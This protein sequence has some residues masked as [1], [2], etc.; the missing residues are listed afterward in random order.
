M[1]KGE[2]MDYKELN[3][4]IRKIANEHTKMVTGLKLPN[5]VLLQFRKDDSKLLSINTF[6]KLIG[7]L[8]LTADITLKDADGNE[9]SVEDLGAIVKERFGDV[10][11]ETLATIAGVKKEKKAEASMPSADEISIPD[12]GATEGPKAPEVV[13]AAEEAKK[14]S[15]ETEVPVAASP[16]VE[17]DLSDIFG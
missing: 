7:G 12:A 8:G 10:K 14:D 15:A 16:E 3:D 13:A 1:Q 9:V 5:T 11:K 17:V 4:A 6:M 2:K